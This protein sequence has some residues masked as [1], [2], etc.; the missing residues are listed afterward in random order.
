M[1]PEQAAICRI[2]RPIADPV[3]VELGA[4]IG[5]D[6]ESWLGRE[7]LHIMVEPDPQ[8]VAR[9]KPLPMRRI[10][11]AAIAAQ[12]GE[13]VFHFSDD[14]KG[15]SWS[16]SILEPTGHLV[17]NPTTKFAVKPGAAGRV[18][19]I[20]LDELYSQQQLTKV[21]L[22]WVDIQGAEGE[23]ISGGKS[24]LAHTRYLF[25]ETEDV[26]YYQGQVLKSDLL[27]MLSGWKVLETF[28]YDVLLENTEVMG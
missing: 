8:N 22:L 2:L 11:Q 4:Y 1:Y 23:M 7:M 17:I 16:G 19:C 6:F 26:E 5:E 12:A 25:M 28:Q 13:R 20:T 21:D 3:I 9:I 14:G 24:A 27:K 10:V 18:Q 15:H